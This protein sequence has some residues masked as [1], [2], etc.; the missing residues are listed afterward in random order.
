MVPQDQVARLRMTLAENGLPKG[1]GVG[2]EIFDKSDA[3]GT[4]S[5]VQNI[6][7]LRA[8]E[9]ELAR[10]IRTL[11]QVEDARVHLV[12]PERP[13]FSRDKVEPSASIVLK[14]RGTLEP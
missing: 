14:L 12:M 10:T 13:L 7:N 8:L 2:Y 4:T 11:D 1:G 6:D 3:L 5:F 9:G